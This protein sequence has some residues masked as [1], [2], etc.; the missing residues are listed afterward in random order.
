MCKITSAA[1]A[2]S[3]HIYC[4]LCLT[5]LFS[6]VLGSSVMEKPAYTCLATL[7]RNHRSKSGGFGG[8]KAVRDK[9]RPVIDVQILMLH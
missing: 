2:N 5:N 1:M 8:P 6:D 3:V 9:S 4:C 7:K